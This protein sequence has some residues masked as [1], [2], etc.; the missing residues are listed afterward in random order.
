MGALGDLRAP[1]QVRRVRLPEAVLSR[2]RVS[3]S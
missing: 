1:R 3:A 2:F